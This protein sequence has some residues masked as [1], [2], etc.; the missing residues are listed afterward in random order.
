MFDLKFEFLFELELL[1]LNYNSLKE[2][3]KWIFVFQIRR[4]Y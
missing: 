2:F 4:L 1:N 3:V